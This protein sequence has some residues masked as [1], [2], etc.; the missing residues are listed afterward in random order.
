MAVP[1]ILPETFPDSPP[2]EIAFFCDPRAALDA[3]YADCQAA[4][5]SID[6]EQYIFVDDDTGSRFLKLFEDKARQGIRVRLL[7]D[8]IGSRSLSVSRRVF[9][10]RDAG[11]EVRFY[12]ALNW[13]NLFT[14]RRWL[15]RN[16][17]KVMMIDNRI[18]HV[19]SLGHWHVMRDWRELHA[20]FTGALAEQVVQ[21]FAQLW[22]K[23]GRKYHPLPLPDQPESGCRFIVSEPRIGHGRVYKELLA[24]IRRAQRRICLVT[25]Y[26]LPPRRLRRA[27][28]QA[29]RRGI[30]VNVVLSERTDVP[31]ADYASRAYFR[32]LIKS[33]VKIHLY[34]PSILHAKYT[35]IDDDWATIGSTNLDYLSLL[36]NREANIIL[37]TPETVRQISE[38]FNETLNQSRPVD[39]SYWRALPWH[40]KLLGYLSHLIRKAL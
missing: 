40:Q 38:I 18:A 35:L 4:Q 11:V 37:R 36:H 31:I 2:T 33:G 7:F 30:E 39:I 13:R 10:L 19:S 16:H 9:A 24:Q 23:Q 34:T 29:S 22:A 28:K 3:L 27:L 26:F 32:R 1:E 12:N 6:I 17:N 21:H 15:P 25:P 20:R 8:G 14:P 5:Q